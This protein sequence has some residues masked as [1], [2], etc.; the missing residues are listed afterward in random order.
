MLYYRDLEEIIFNRHEIHDTNELV[1]LSGYVSP[2]PIRKLETLPLPVKVI[3]GMYPSNG[4]SETLHHSLVNLQHNIDNIDIYY[5]SSPIHS[6]CYAWK[7]NTD[8]IHALVG[9]ANFTSSGL[10]TPYREVLA[11]ATRDTFRPLNDYINNILHSAILCNDADISI[12]AIGA[13][14]IRSRVTHALGYCRMTLLDPATNETQNA[15]GLNWGQNES[16][17]TNLNDAN[18][19]IRADY[20]RNYPD[21]FPEKQDFSLVGNQ[22][23]RSQRN[24]DAIDI[25]WDDG[26]TMR[27]LLEGSND[28]ISG[29]LGIRF[30][31]QIS[32]FPDKSELGRYLRQRI[33]VPSGQRVERT[34]LE[35]YGRTHIDVSLI[36]E[37]IYRFDFSVPV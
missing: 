10:C 4:I 36:D 37:G 15:N 13:R 24:N 7:N 33:G 26:T 3:Y 27:G 22:G 18:I 11:E 6:K 14:T 5:S 2:P 23:G 28:R 19:P 17:H 20:I 31:K 34:D 12:G 30:P 32:S 25:I 1:I 29:F 9:S 16:N 8:V 35:R 21:L